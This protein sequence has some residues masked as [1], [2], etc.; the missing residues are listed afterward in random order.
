VVIFAFMPSSPSPP[1][2]SASFFNVP[3]SLILYNVSFFYFPFFFT[4]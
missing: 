2:F 1:T 3:L 4:Y